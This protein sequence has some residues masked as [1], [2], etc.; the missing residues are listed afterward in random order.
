M[1][2]VAHPIPDTHLYT[3]MIRACAS[4][5]EPERA[6][7]LWTELTHDRAVEPNTSAYNAII[8]ACARSGEKQYVQQ[9]LRLAKEMMDAHRD[10]SGRSAF[11]RTNRLL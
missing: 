11:L 9:A 4:P 3:V 7:D 5:P 6:L 1:R 10:A 8:Y 2:Y